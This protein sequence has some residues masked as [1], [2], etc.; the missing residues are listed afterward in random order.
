MRV[1]AIA[2]L[3][4]LGHVSGATGSGRR[5]AVIFNGG[6]GGALRE[7]VAQRERA[8]AEFYRARGYEVVVLSAENRG[9]TPDKLKQTLAG[10]RGVS[11]LQLDF[12]AH[13]S[14][15][16]P[17]PPRGL[18]PARFPVTTLSEPQYASRFPFDAA[19]RRNQFEL[20]VEGQR[21]AVGLADIRGPL[22]EFQRANPSSVT[23]LLAGNCFS[24]H[25]A[26]ELS[27]LPRFRAF[28]STAA[29][30]V[31]PVCKSSSGEDQDQM[32]WMKEGLIAGSSYREAQLHA[33]KRQLERCPEEENLPFS[34]RQ[35]L[36]PRNSM[37]GFIQ[38]W[39]QGRP[40]G[41]ARSP[42][43]PDPGTDHAQ[44]VEPTQRELAEVRAARVKLCDPALEIRDEAQSAAHNRRLTSKILASIRE[45]MKRLSESNARELLAAL[46]KKLA[47]TEAAPAEA[48]SGLSDEQKKMR[49]EAMASMR[50][51]IAALRAAPSLR[52]AV[53]DE[54]R[55]MFGEVERCLSRGDT[56][57]ECKG[58]LPVFLFDFAGVLGVD[59]PPPNDGEDDAP[60]GP[61]MSEKDPCGPKV[62][63]Q[64]ARQVVSNI[65]AARRCRMAAAG[66]DPV[67]LMSALETSE[68][69]YR[70][71]CHF[72]RG[73][74]REMDELLACSRRFY[75]EASEPDKLH[76]RSMLRLAREV[77]PGVQEGA[78]GP[79]PPGQEGE[80]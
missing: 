66:D 2:C 32:M 33:Q 54:M 8:A 25:L 34:V 73:R 12:I 45:R 30:T 70:A 18:D 7:V 16:P 56:S 22:E 40:P 63:P 35:F 21:E 76:L 13:G 29:Q 69:S 51:R 41:P 42:R 1:L 39:C 59:A 52:G 48:V 26:Q 17:G 14:V 38:K 28:V 9:A 46:E 57:E 50:E 31:A 80:R 43:A 24:G 11:D 72:L 53:E 64:S 23:T 49:D 5:V 74:E 36:L 37:Q 44:L 71:H 4:L 60:E 20:P 65:Q 10:L 61:D 78:G 67:G 55:G 27:D 15:V 58:I 6:D 68:N 3:V 77:P 47:M 19:E 79:K 62:A 75:N